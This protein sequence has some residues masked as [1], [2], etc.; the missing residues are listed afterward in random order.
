MRLDGEI[1]QRS[2]TGSADARPEAA[3]DQRTTSM[4][5]RNT[6]LI[7][8]D[9]EAVLSSQDSG[10][11]ASCLHRKVEG[12]VRGCASGSESDAPIG[13]LHTGRQR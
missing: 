10:D 2:A 6:A 13:A 7:S 1:A 12:S 5:Q 3:C 8:A 9:V 4:G 11:E